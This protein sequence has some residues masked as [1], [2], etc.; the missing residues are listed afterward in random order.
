MASSPRFMPGMAAALLLLSLPAAA[1]EGL[2]DTGKA[3]L[4]EWLRSHN[5]LAGPPARSRPVVLSNRGH[6]PVLCRLTLAHWYVIDMDPVPPG[7]T[8]SLPFRHDAATGTVS[9]LNSEGV[10]MAVEGL[11]CGPAGAGT[12]IDFR[13]LVGRKGSLTC[14][15]VCAAD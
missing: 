6:A 4:P 9:W 14:G 13:K 5:Y 7:R 12:G 2:Y 1:G 8:V 11:S 3:D 10:D 15:R